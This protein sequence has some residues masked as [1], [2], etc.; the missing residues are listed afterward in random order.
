M[1]QTLS[2]S[3]SL[4]STGTIRRESRIVFV[5]FNWHPPAGGLEIS[6]C[7]NLSF[8]SNVVVSYA[9]GS[10]KLSSTQCCR[11]TGVAAEWQHG[12]LVMAIM[13]FK[14]GE[15]E[16]SL[17]P[18]QRGSCIYMK[19]REAPACWSGSAVFRPKT[20]NRQVPGLAA[21]LCVCA[22]VCVCVCVFA[23]VCVCVCVRVRV[24]VCVCV[25]VCMCV[26]VC[27]CVCVC[28]YSDRL[29]SKSTTQ[30][31]VSLLENSHKSEQHHHP[32]T[33]LSLAASFTSLFCF[34]FP[35]LC[36]YQ[37]LKASCSKQKSNKKKNPD[38]KNIRKWLEYW[39]WTF[40]R[41]LPFI[42]KGHRRTLSWADVIIA[43]GT[44]LE[45]SGEGCIHFAK[46]IMCFCF[47][48]SVA[49]H[50]WKLLNLVVFTSWHLR[51]CLLHAQLRVC[52]LP[53]TVFI[54]PPLVIICLVSLTTCSVY[55]W[56]QTT[57]SRHGFF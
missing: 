43:T 50:H 45:H 39:V 7:G 8:S 37:K 53:V 55:R 28:D 9:S 48:Q 21:A 17:A 26:C 38:C 12:A 35:K 15:P 18:K 30:T 13:A 52:I 46:E 33:T 11:L 34:S 41:S 56:A 44:C 42:Y 47:E 23:C 54:L 29:I 2:Y 31:I 36:G 1:K 32:D 22:C 3:C 6:Q 57:L 51:V 20:V 4:H 10:W 5:R 19:N 14:A 25:C 40:L 49:S 27:V 16:F 24:C